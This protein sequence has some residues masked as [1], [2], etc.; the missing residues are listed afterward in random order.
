MTTPN[1][2]CLKG[3]KEKEDESNIFMATVGLIDGSWI[4]E[5]GTITESNGLPSGYTYISP[6]L[7]F[8]T[9]SLNGMVLRGVG[10][11]AQKRIRLCESSKG[12]TSQY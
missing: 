11:N 3:A 4:E 2:P 5:I 12:E 7:T 1:R 10:N 9:S 6:Y 8:S